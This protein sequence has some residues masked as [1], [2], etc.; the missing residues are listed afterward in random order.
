MDTCSR[1]R[2]LPQD[3]PKRLS[4]RETRSARNATGLSLSVYWSGSR[5]DTEAPGKT[6]TR[7]SETSRRKGLRPSQDPARDLQL[8][9]LSRFCANTGGADRTGHLPPPGCGGAVATSWPIDSGAPA[10]PPPASN[11]GDAGPTSQPQPV[12]VVPAGGRSARFPDEGSGGLTT[13]HEA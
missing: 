6:R 1:R 13:L 12:A 10:R 4:A 2:S 11:S 9:E 3:A 8:D 7:P 5:K